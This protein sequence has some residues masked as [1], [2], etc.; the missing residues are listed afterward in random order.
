M[1]SG[2][3]VIVGAIAALSEVASAQDKP[4]YKTLNATDY[5]TEANDL[6]GKRVTV[7]DCIFWGTSIS[8]GVEQ[9]GKH[10][11]PGKYFYIDLGTL[12]REALRRAWRTCSGIL[13]QAN[14]PKDKCRGSVT[15]IVSPGTGQP[16]YNRPRLKD[17]TI[18]WAQ[19]GSTGPRL[20]DATRTQF[21]I[22]DYLVDAKDLVGKRITVTDCS[23]T[24]AD[25]TSV[26]CA[27]PNYRFF[28]NIESDTLDGV[29]LRRA[30]TTCGP[31]FKFKDIQC[32]GSVTGI[33][34]PGPH[35]SRRLRDATIEWAQ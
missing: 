18:E 9:T 30:L 3:L 31:G 7:T 11:E 24:N 15:G 17:A 16:P 5:L 26:T 1:R 27:D 28:F 34:S 32:H 21:E 29:S 6:M 23:F 33:V 20:K 25:T 13:S 35:D 19:P 8:C 14:F 12:E 4:V 22:I 2:L 10:Y